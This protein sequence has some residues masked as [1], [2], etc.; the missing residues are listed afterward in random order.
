[1]KLNM[2]YALTFYEP[3]SEETWVFFEA[4]AP[5]SPFAVGDIIRI[6]KEKEENEEIEVSYP[7]G[8]LPTVKSR[9]QTNKPKLWPEVEGVTF[10]TE[11]TVTK[12]VH[13]ISEIQKEE[14]ILHHVLISTKIHK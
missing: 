11:L 1:M 12:V 10:E 9:V 6:P 13:I 14:E 7:A 3:E 5:F 2:S 8:G 4:S